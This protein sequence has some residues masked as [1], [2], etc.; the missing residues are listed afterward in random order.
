[1]RVL[2]LGTPEFAVATLKALIAC[3]DFEV[4][5][6]VCQPD[7]P[8]GRG[9]KLT[10]PPVKIVALEHDIPVLQ[11]EKLAKAPEIVEQMKA[12]KPDVIVMVAFG[13][14]LKKAVLE[15]APYGVINLHGS[16][17]P[18]LR[19]AAPINWSIINGEKVTGVTTMVTEAG[20]DTGPMLLKAEVPIGNDMNAE[21]LAHEMA[22]IGAPLV[23]ETLRGLKAGTVKPQAQNDAEATYAPI[24]TKEMGAID[25]NKPA[26]EIHNLVRG[27]YPW[28]GTYSQFRDGTLKII[29]TTLPSGLNLE[30]ANEAGVVSRHQEHILV[31]CG[32][33]GKESI[34]LLQ[35]QP[36]NKAKMNARDWYNGLRLTSPERFGSIHV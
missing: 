9:N 26:Q 35:V 15:L 13:Q 2:F 31:S 1:M 19:G 33:G 12:L 14:I 5:G 34:V 6:A 18:K 3:Q 22:S 10:Q 7:R 21:E 4:V 17:L 27:L 28:P 20:V 36:A 29:K 16:L 8:S 30:A 25:W 24:M 23:V 32:N 11:P